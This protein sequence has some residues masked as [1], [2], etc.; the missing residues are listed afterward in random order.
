MP[1]APPIVTAY[2]CAALLVNVARYDVNAYGD[3]E[4][5]R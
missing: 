3:T 1:L 2:G 5:V 4:N